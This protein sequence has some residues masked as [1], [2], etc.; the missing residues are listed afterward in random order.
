MR[1]RGRHVFARAL[2]VSEAKVA[3]DV[4]RP[5]EHSDGMNLCGEQKPLRSLF[6]W[7][8]MGCGACSFLA[9]QVQCHAHDA[10]GSASARQAR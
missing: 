6:A 10:R 1:I 5:L 7:T 3:V 8:M 4:Q 2:N 9:A